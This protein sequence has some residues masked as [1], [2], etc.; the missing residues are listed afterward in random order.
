MDVAIKAIRGVTEEEWAEVKSMANERG[1][2]IG[3][4]IMKA[5]REDKKTSN[6]A[7]WEKILSWKAKDPKEVEGIEERIREFRKG[8]GLRSFK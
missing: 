1:L 2:S 5:V 4:Y 7:R 8:F 3:R 6:R